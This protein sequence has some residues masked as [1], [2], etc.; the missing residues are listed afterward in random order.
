MWHVFQGFIFPF[1]KFLLNDNM[2]FLF[3][4]I[5]T[6]WHLFLKELE[7]WY[8]EESGSHENASLETLSPMRTEEHRKHSELIHPWSNTISGQDMGNTGVSGGWT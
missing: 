5:H 2:M 7:W 6:L 8:G 1:I 3:L 4:D